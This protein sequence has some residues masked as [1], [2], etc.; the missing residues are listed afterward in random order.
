MK[1]G[2]RSNSA[3]EWMAAVYEKFTASI[4]LSQDT[5]L[6]LADRQLPLVAHRAQ[7]GRKERLVLTV[8]YTLLSL[9]AIGTPAHAKLANHPVWRRTCDLF[10]IP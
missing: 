3:G 1:P 2:K 7:Y 5:P 4:M 6:N 9:R 8:L 10:E